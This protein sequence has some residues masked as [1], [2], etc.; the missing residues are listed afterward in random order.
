M[1]DGVA[2]LPQ[3]RGAF[4]SPEARATFL[5]DLARTRVESRVDR[6]SRLGPPARSLGQP[7]WMQ[8][9]RRSAGASFTS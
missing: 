5:V 3:P 2:A 6:S 8:P 4:E 7:L 1:G 9:P